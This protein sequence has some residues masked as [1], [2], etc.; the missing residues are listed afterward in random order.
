MSLFYPIQMIADSLC[1]F[2]DLEVNSRNQ[3]YRI[4]LKSQDSEKDW[5]ADNLDTAYQE[6]ARVAQDKLICGHNFRRF[7]YPHLVKKLPEWENKLIVDTLELAIIL[8]P[9]EKSHKLNKDYKPSQFSSNNP[10]EDACTTRLLLTHIIER[11]LTLPIAMQKTYCWLLSCGM[12][13]SDQAYRRFFDLLGFNELVSTP[14]HQLPSLAVRGLNI[15]YLEHFWEDASTKTFESRLCLAGILAWNYERRQQT[16]SSPSFCYWL[17]HLQDFQT[18]RNYMM[19]LPHYHLLTERFGIK[20]FR[21]KQ[22]E[23]IKAILSQQNILTI[24]PTGGGKSL[25]YQIPALTLFENYQ[26]LTVVI[27]PLQALM[28]DQVKD[29]EQKNLHFATFIN[30]NLSIAERSRRLQKIREDSKGLVYISPEQLRAVSIRDL[31]QTKLPE[32]WVIDEAHCISQWGHDFRPD[33]RYIPQFI[34][35]IY[36]EGNYPTIALMT[37]TARQAVQEDIRKLFIN[38]GLSIDNSLIEDNYFR[39]NLHYQIVP[40]NGNKESALIEQVQKLQSQKGAILIYTTT[41][42][43]V[44]KLSA[45]LNQLGLEARHYHG[46]ISRE[47]KQE[48]LKQFKN[49]EL[50]IVTATCAFGMGINRPDVRAVI[51]HT[52]SA[53]LESYIQETGRAG[54]DGNPANCTLLFD[55]EDADSIRLNEIPRRKRTG[56][57]NKLNCIFW[58]S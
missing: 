36:Q 12:E 14:L 40:I 42:K 26:A 45:R 24:M 25:C 37:A 4:G 18:I 51:H 22:E 19:P 33:Y 13:N 58:C 38:H 43:N 11:F 21:G 32:I 31:L 3:I 35:E 29:L 39:D 50:N 2:L 15:D 46:R 9:L 34:Q 55:P 8:F 57:Q 54:R 6:L 53:N 20:H 56:Y 44:E 48:V 30:K 16:Q 10:L 7:D 27:S 28:E 47:E 17:S 1:I 5:S 49:G 23:A 41:R 52:M